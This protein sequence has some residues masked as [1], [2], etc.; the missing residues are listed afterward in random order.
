M[1]EDYIQIIIN[2]GQS[3]VCFSN[4]EVREAVYIGTPYAPEI[5]TGRSGVSTSISRSQAMQV[6]VPVF[7]DCH[8]TYYK[9]RHIE[10]TV[11]GRHTMRLVLSR[12]FTAVQPRHSCTPGTIVSPEG[13]P[14][15]IFGNEYIDG[16]SAP[17]SKVYKTSDNVPPQESSAPVVVP[18]VEDI[19]TAVTGLAIAQIIVNG[20]ATI[21]TPEIQDEVTRAGLVWQPFA[22][23]CVV[24]F[25]KNWQ[26]IMGGK[27]LRKTTTQLT[28]SRA[29]RGGLAVPTPVSIGADTTPFVDDSIGGSTGGGFGG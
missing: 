29:K 16:L 20:A 15:G 17:Q 25:Q 18:V 5:F 2:G 27:G 13:Y 21:W 14:W 22:M 7:A 11:R 1:I 12:Y 19:T 3:S 6:T 28:F 10:E 9:L 23:E 8:G 24:D 26:Q 4:R